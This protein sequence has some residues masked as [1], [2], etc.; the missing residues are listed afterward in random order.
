MT[1]SVDDPVRD[2]RLW[3]GAE[4]ARVVDQQVDA[5]EVGGDGGEYGAVASIGDVTRNRAYGSGSGCDESLGDRR[6]RVRP[7]CV[8]D[9]GPAPLGQRQRKRPAESLRCAGDECGRHETSSGQVEKSPPDC[10]LKFT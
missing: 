5:S 9:Q 4:R 3:A 8:D 1:E 10:D 7:P 6:E 2:V